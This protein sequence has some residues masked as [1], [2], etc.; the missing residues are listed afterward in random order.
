MESRRG[1]AGRGFAF[2]LG[3]VALITP[4]AVH[5]FLPV[6]PAVKLALGLP[7]SAA[8]LTFTIALFAMAFATLVYG[9][10]SD[11]YGRRPLLLSGLVLF[12]I[13]SAISAIAQTAPVLAL[14]RLVQAV[15]AGCSMTLVRTIARDAYR[16]EHL[17]RAIA[18]LTMFYTLGPM[19]AP[20]VGGVLIDTLGW[21]SVFGFA[22]I[23][24]GIITVA[25]Y[26]GIP[27][28]RPPRDPALAQIEL[29][30]G[31]AELFSRPQFVG[32]VLQSG[33]NTAAF[34][35]MASASATLMKEL[36]HRP[37]SEFGFYFLLFPVGFFFG[38]FV[39]SR[40]GSR[41]SS[42]AMVLTGSLLA[43]AT[44]AVQS[45]L[46]LSGQVAP[47]TF[48]APGFFLTFSQGI[49]LPYAQVG[50]MAVI[51]R[52]A[53][54]AAGIGVFMQNF[55]GGVFAQLYGFFANGTPLPMIAI[56]ACS[57]AL[58]VAAGALPFAF[59]R[60]VADKL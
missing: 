35:T 52:L 57:G 12:L 17:V 22:L 16:A 23:A 58:C 41:V 32:Y 50:A 39:S 1:A 13:G 25:A 49:A 7:D 27:E 38:T 20:L 19:L 56:L 11:R 59:R 2:A 14:G 53:G 4:L 5:L 45:V 3:L 51:P 46:F 18:Y 42:E 43:L 47:L 26:L 6:I 36:L 15:G 60:S 21:R 34:M 9:S 37:S 40:V 10:L 54:T 33:F 28:T 29:L 30:R 48:F 31:Y 44:I 8:Q 24:G 55:G